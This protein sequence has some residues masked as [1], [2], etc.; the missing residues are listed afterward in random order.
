MSCFKFEPS[1]TL[2]MLQEKH[3]INFSSK[4]AGSTQVKPSNSFFPEFFLNF[5]SIIGK[6]S[7]LISSSNSPIFNN[8]TISF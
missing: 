6:P 4:H 7:Q 1:N 5:L 2:T 3:I 8:I